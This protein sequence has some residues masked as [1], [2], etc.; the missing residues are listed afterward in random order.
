MLCTI[1]SISMSSCEVKA[2]L[3]SLKFKYLQMFSNGRLIQ[4]QYNVKSRYVIMFVIH[5]LRIYARLL[6]M[7]CII[8][9]SVKDL[10]VKYKKC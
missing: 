4:Q 9:F 10:Y 3:H 1:Y 6:N 7:L 8:V 5:D 2:I